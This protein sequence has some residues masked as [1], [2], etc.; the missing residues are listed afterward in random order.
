MA[1]VLQ[2]PRYGA[3]PS[4]ALVAALYGSAGRV[5]APPV[6][7]SV[8][9]AYQWRTAMA[10]DR[11]PAAVRAELPRAAFLEETFKLK[12]AVRTAVPAQS[13]RCG[14]HLFATV[15]DS[16]ELRTVMTDGQLL[17]GCGFPDRDPTHCLHRGCTV[18]AAQWHAL[19]FNH[20]KVRSWE[21]YHSKLEK[22]KRV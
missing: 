8:T 7:A 5:W 21:E 22:G 2:D 4:V 9:A 1:S 14:A 3:A 13:G 12:S 20:Y 16:T 19:R 17:R 6:G 18:G 10:Y 11:L 15:P